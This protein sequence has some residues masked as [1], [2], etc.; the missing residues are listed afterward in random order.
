MLCV[1]L[2]ITVRSLSLS[3]P[4]HDFRTT[5]RPS[6]LS[7][8]NQYEQ[9]MKAASMAATT[10]DTLVLSCPV[11]VNMLKEGSVRWQQ[12]PISFTGQRPLTGHESSAV[13]A[14][15][16][17][18]AIVTKNML[19]I[20]N[21]Q[22]TDAGRWV[23]ESNASLTR[24]ETALEVTRPPLL[25]IRSSIVRP[26]LGEPLTLNCTTRF[27][28]DGDANV[29]RSSSGLMTDEVVWMR[30]ATPIRLDERVQRR[31][32]GRILHLATFRYADNGLY[33]CFTTRN[34]YGGQSL[35]WT[36]ARMLLR[37]PRKYL[38]HTHEM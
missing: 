15:S 20:T 33:Q 8:Y 18:R 27:Y 13:N 16:I 31:N 26:R 9:S 35:Q 30:D 11:N 24:H 36:H 3:P 28:G 34:G 5:E 1:Q 7:P 21:V 22:E 25:E 14:L 23:C 2:I 10:G 12:Y 6:N 17:D 32:N 19:I 4:R 38:V 37:I 29:H